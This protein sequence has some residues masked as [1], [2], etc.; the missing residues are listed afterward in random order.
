MPGFFLNTSLCSSLWV[1]GLK[2]RRMSL[3]ALLSCFAKIWSILDCQWWSISIV[4]LVGF[5]MLPERFS[6]RRRQTSNVEGTVPQTGDSESSTS[7][8]LSQ[9]PVWECSVASQPLCNPTPAPATRGALHHPLPKCE[10][11]EI[12]LSAGGFCPIFHHSDETCNIQCLAGVSITTS[13]YS[14]SFPHTSRP[15]FVPCGC[16]VGWELEVCLEGWWEASQAAALP[17]SRCWELHSTAVPFNSLWIEALL[18]ETGSAIIL[19]N[20]SLSSLQP[21]GLPRRER[22]DLKGQGTTT[23]KTT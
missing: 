6:W 19:D 5:R 11:K 9:L 3:T 13:F 23:V 20:F 16:C 12:F 7:S 2:V 4:N 15:I 18:M 21:G 10:L 17:W 8:Q 1:V 14:R 22:L